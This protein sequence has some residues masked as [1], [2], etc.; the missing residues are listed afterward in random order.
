MLQV[1]LN[2][3]DSRITAFVYSECSKF[4]SVVSVKL[5]LSQ[6]PLAYVEMTNR[7]HALN[8]AADS[9]CSILGNVVAVHLTQQ[10]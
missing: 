2:E 5:R 9:G 10:R 1:D 7:Q 6:S 8:L 4:G 3:S